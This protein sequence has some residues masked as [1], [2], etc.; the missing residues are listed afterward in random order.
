[1]T[2]GG[3]VIFVFVRQVTAAAAT[4]VESHGEIGARAYDGCLAS[5]V[6]TLTGP[7]PLTLPL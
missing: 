3:V 6:R 5:Q 4:T 1:M 7:T 2:F